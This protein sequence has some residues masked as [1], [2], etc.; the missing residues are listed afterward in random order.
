M[1]QS[2]TTRHLT[3]VTE[4]NNDRLP[5]PPHRYLRSAVRR[6]IVRLPRRSK[7]QL[8]EGQVEI[9]NED[10]RLKEFQVCCWNSGKCAVV[11][12]CPSLVVFADQFLARG[13]CLNPSKPP[14]NPPVVVPPV[15]ANGNKRPGESAKQ[16]NTTSRMCL[17]S[18]AVTQVKEV[19]ISIRI[20]KSG[21]L[22]LPR[23]T[24]DKNQPLSQPVQD[25]KNILEVILPHR[26]FPKRGFLHGTSPHG[27]LQ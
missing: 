15:V 2:F 7:P 16:N 11:S 10:R 12:R 25:F 17:C 3:T 19:A 4:K 20:S 9:R 14:S 6:S 18:V 22:L 26:Q 1:P 23:L 13:R 21:T 27:L 8:G 5:F 24:V